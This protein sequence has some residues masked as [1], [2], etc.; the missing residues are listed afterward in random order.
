MIC[1]LSLPEGERDQ[2]GQALAQFITNNYSIQD[3][4]KVL[5]GDT[6][7]KIINR[8]LDYL[9]CIENFFYDKASSWSCWTSEL[10]GMTGINDKQINKGGDVYILYYAI[11][12]AQQTYSGPE[13]LRGRGW[14][15]VGP[16]CSVPQIT[17]VDDTEFNEKQKRVLR[18]EHMR[19]Y[20]PHGSAPPTT[21]IEYNGVWVSPHIFM[22]HFANIFAKSKVGG[23]K[24]KKNKRKTKRKRRKS[25]RKTKR[26]KYKTKRSR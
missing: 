8:Y 5:S 21:G 23:G 19:C 25:K 3:P 24:I 22:G 7:D 1:D 14:S 10:K 2:L 12:A 15:C 9:I 18:I 17:Q 13:K 16:V 6:L 4:L 11:K 26:R 20:D